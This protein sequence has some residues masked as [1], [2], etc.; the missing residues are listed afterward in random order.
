MAVFIPRPAKASTRARVAWGPL[1][2]QV[3]I[4]MALGLTTGLLLGPSGAGILSEPAGEH[5]IP[6]IALPGNMF[7]AL[8][9][10]VVIPLVFRG[11]LKSPGSYQASA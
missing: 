1:W 8:I 3:L 11:C 6:W 2:L 7:L 5:V 4:A 10:M 9:K